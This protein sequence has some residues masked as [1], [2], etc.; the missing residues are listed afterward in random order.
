MPDPLRLVDLVARGSLLVNDGYRTRADQL[1]RPGIPVLRVAD[2]QQGHLTATFS[3][4]VLETYRS[5]IADKVSRPRDVVVTTK[6][7]VGRVALISV[8]HSEFVYSPQVCFFRCLDDTIDPRWLYYWFRGPEFTG[9]ASGVQAQTD[10]AAYIN[11]ADMRAMRLTLPELTE[12]RAVA[13][14][15]GALD[16]KIESNRR[17][18]DTC[19]GLL[20]ATSSSLALELDSVPLSALVA[21]LRDAFDPSALGAESIDHFS[22]PAFDAKGLPDRTSGA[23]VISAKLRVD[24]PSVLVSRLNPATNRT[25]FAVPQPGVTAGCSTEFLVLTPTAGVTL[26]SLW[27]AVRDERFRS[28]LAQ[29][30]TGTSGSHQRVKAQDALATEVP[31]VR[32]LPAAEAKA[33]DDLLWLKHQRRVESTRLAT[34]RDALLPEL[35]SRAHPSPGSRDDLIY[36]HALTRAAAYAQRHGDDGAGVR[37][38][39]STGGGP[40]RPTG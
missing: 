12:Q 19:S 11:L 22:I 31:D 35:L 9:Q 33:A 13:S 7:T 16:D 21:P 14:R 28:L 20:D 8:D 30:A 40:C 37:R 36:V 6:G 26:G 4:H 18:I 3:D 2:V 15:L 1:G 39:A 23:S 5:K 17:T 10:M 27:L 24:Q 32:R 34:L 38:D 29:R 25:W